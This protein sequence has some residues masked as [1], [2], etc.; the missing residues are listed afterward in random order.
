MAQGK[1]TNYLV[2]GAM[3]LAIYLMMLWIGR[4]FP[5]ELAH[6]R[7]AIHLLL[8]LGLAAV[9]YG[10]R[11]REQ[12]NRPPLLKRKVAGPPLLRKKP[13]PAPPAPPVKPK[14]NP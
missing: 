7:S 11:Q 3:I 9:A 6:V 1:P 14:E 2:V 4:Y 8:V 12:A 10:W 5:P 13:K